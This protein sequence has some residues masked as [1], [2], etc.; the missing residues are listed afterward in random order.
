MVYDRAVA[1]HATQRP[2]QRMPAILRDAISI[3]KQHQRAFI[4]LNAAFYGL[5]ALSMLATLFA[6]ELQAQFKP[7]IDESFEKPGLFNTVAG[8]YASRDLPVAI[9]MTFL[10]NLV[11]ASIAMA[12]LPTFV[13][14]FVGIPVVL[15][16]AFLWGVMFAPIGP[17]AVTL[18]PHSLTLLIEGQAYVLVA[19]AAYVQARMFLWPERYGLIRHRDGYMAGAVSTLKLYPLVMLALAAGAIYEVI[20]AVY[21]MPLLLRS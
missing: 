13:V 14:P 11:V 17:L 19:F 1:D 4:V 2:K 9:G 10:V 18:V 3:I 12:T 8:A 20:E 7:S 5:V 6:P 16:R 21:V 15:Y